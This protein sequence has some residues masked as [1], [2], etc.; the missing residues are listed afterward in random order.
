[1]VTLTDPMSRRTRRNLV[2]VTILVLALFGIDRLSGGWI[3][4]P[5]SSVAVTISQGASAV[6]RQVFGDGIFSS[7]VSLAAENESLKRQLA[8]LNEEVAAARASE[9][10]DAQLRALAHLATSTKGISTHVVSSFTASP[11]GTF[12]IGA[13]TLQGIHNGALVLSPDA[14]VIG[15][16]SDARSSQSVVSETFAAGASVDVIAG[17]VPITLSGKGGGFATGDAPRGS[18]IASGTPAIAPA[19]GGRTVGF[20]ERTEGSAAS[21]AVKTYVRAPVNLTTLD[22]VYVETQ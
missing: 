14:F 5:V 22:L 18:S 16:V 7:R 19:F 20:V 2:L 9:A 15:L 21:A 12:L 10:E 13:G 6:Y 11:Y 3:R 4:R 1:M 17:D 8:A